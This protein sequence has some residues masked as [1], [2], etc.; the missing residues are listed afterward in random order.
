MPLFEQ[1]ADL[2]FAPLGATKRGLLRFFKFLR[3]DGRPNRSFHPN[4][5]PA[6]LSDRQP[7]T[8]AGRPFSHAFFIHMRHETIDIMNES[9]DIPSKQPV[10]ACRSFLSHEFNPEEL[11]RG[12][13][14]QSAW[15]EEEI[16]RLLVG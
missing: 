13:T 9:A 3:I 2:L 12:W 1:S 10:A 14:S 6:L 15:I 7:P 8:G 4:E 16:P 5:Q 11:E